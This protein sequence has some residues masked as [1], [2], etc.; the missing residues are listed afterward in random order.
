MGIKSG[1]RAALVDHIF[2]EVCAARSP[3]IRDVKAIDLYALHRK[4]AGIG[5]RRISVFIYP[6]VSLDAI[7][8]NYVV[9]K[10]CVE[11]IRAADIIISSALK[12][13]V[14]YKYSVGGFVCKETCVMSAALASALA[15]KRYL[16]LNGMLYAVY[17]C[18]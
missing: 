18:M 7:F 2:A 13:A 11:L 4:S 12:N 9:Y 14:L 15:F 1:K 5:L 17:N 16:S 6:E 10:S 8:K 3:A